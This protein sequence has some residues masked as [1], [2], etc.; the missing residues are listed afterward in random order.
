VTDDDPLLDGD[1]IR[2]L[3]RRLGERLHRRGVVGDIY[4]VGGAAMALAFD[5]RWATRDIDAG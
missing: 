5:A 1:R 4:V 3:F 2:D